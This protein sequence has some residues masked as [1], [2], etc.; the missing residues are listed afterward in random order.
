MGDAFG[1]K[2][3]IVNAQGSSLGRPGE[4]ITNPIQAVSTLSGE[5]DPVKALQMFQ[6][7][8]TAGGPPKPVDPGQIFA[9]EG[10]VAAETE[11]ADAGAGFAGL[12]GFGNMIGSIAPLNTSPMQPGVPYAAPPV[13]SGPPDVSGR[14]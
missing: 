9:E 5:K 7:W 3:G 8:L 6:N 14:K 12:F 10:T 1:S 2:P 4:G 11:R 13:P